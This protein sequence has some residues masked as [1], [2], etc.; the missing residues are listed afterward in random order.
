MTD[1]C[2]QAE[3]CLDYRDILS[4]VISQSHFILCK[5]STAPKILD[6]GGGGKVN[7]LG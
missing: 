4:N 7:Q 5:Q 3:K 2:K 1:E 6:G